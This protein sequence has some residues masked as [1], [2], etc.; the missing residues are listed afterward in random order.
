MPVPRIEDLAPAPR[1]HG[2]GSRFWAEWCFLRVCLRHF[3]LR[4]LLMAAILLCGGLLFVTF[5]P[6]KNHSMARATYY[7]FSL[8][9][10]EPPE[11]FPT[12]RI[13]Q[14]VFFIV[15]ILG[16]TVIIEG[17]VDFALMLRDRR[18]FEKS[19]C[20]M[21]AK[22]FKDHIVLVGL[23]RLG[24]KTFLIL[25]RLGKAVIVIERDPNNQFLEEVRR[26]GSPLFIGD[27][28]R[29]ALLED[30]NIRCA[31][32]I[33]LATDDD[34]ANLEAALDAVRLNHGVRVVMR[35]FDQNIADKIREGFD[36]QLAMSQAAISAPTFATC[37]IAPAT[38]NSVIVGD[39][40]VAMQRWL[41]RGGDQLCGKTIA[42]VM[43]DHR[44][45]V[46]QHHRPAPQA[47]AAT[48]VCPPPDLVLQ[49]G[50]GLILQGTI[51]TLESL[52]EAAAESAARQSAAAATN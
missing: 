48:I 37:A 22:S 25:R 17:I 19:W 14:A 15:P 1:H 4:F 50:D 5:E 6:E 38:M 30:A 10:G 47:A 35:M 40:L 20:I 8:I 33:I 36:L 49:A 44:I 28:R 52:R 29:E 11:A 26:D 3:R 46:M 32:S 51:Q 7:T 27:A 45:N 43:R 31:T 24:F 16:L 13:L 2:A 21:L 18:R 9:F 41:V 39:Q 23:G 12:S 34:M 42:D